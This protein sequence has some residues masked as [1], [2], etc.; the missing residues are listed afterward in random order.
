MNRS[1]CTSIARPRDRAQVRGTMSAANT[2]N[3]TR[4]PVKLEFVSMLL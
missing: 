3:V 4:E 1:R 2:V